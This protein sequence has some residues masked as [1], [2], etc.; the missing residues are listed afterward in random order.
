MMDP[1]TMMD[2]LKGHITYPATKVQL[3]EACNHMEDQKPE[4]KMEFET[5]LP[6]GTYNSADDVMKALGMQMPM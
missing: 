2:H 3:V 6:D 4:D 5:K 1:K